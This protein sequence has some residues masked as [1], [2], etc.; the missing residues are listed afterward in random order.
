MRLLA[1]VVPEKSVTKNL[2]MAYIE[3]TKIGRT[4]E[5]ISRESPLSLSRHESSSLQGILSLRFL[6]FRVPEKS[7]TKDLTLTYM[8]RSKNER[9]NEQISR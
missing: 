2:T 4:H 6:A 5:Q 9:T 7:L 3:R 1:F 8:E